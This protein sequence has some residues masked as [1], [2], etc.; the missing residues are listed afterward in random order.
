MDFMLLIIQHLKNYLI[1]FGSVIAQLDWAI[2][3][4]ALDYPVKP[5]NDKHWNKIRYAINLQRS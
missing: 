5:D 4:K 2:Q 1:S 3:K